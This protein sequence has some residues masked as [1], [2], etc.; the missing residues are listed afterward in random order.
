[1]VNSKF[2]RS[3]FGQAFPGL[4][5]REPRVVYPCVN[6]TASDD[7]LELDASGKLFEENEIFLSINRYERKKDV[8]LAIRAFAGLSEK[9]RSG[10]RLVVAG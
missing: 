4:K 6:A 5:H 8:G 3:I 10:I 7:T 2:T 9:E 1:V